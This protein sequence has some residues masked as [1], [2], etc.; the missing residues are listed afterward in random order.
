MPCH[1]WDWCHYNWFSNLW[2]L[3]K[4]RHQIRPCHAWTWCYYKRFTNLWVMYKSKHQI[5][6]CHA[7]AWCHCKRFIKKDNWVQGNRTQLI[8]C[9][10]KLVLCQF[11]FFINFARIEAHF[12]I[13]IFKGKLS[14]IRVKIGLM[15]KTY[16]VVARTAKHAL[17]YET[18]SLLEKHTDLS[19]LSKRQKL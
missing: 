7:W 6:S 3:Y 17:L 12:K 8:N 15:K 13:S 4:S 1:A 9:I 14:V 16:L 5:R 11:G 19:C 18:E 10:N 2:L